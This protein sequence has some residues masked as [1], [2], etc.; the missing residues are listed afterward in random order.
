MTRDS[1]DWLDILAKR[2]QVVLGLIGFT[3]W[4][5]T[6]QLQVLYASQQQ[7]ETRKEISSFSEIKAEWPYLKQKVDTMDKKLDILINRRLQ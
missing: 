7:S 3:V 1:F 4:L 5:T 2:W 6:L